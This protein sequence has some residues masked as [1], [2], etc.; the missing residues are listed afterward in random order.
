MLR[1]LTSCASLDSCD[2][3]VGGLKRVTVWSR[4]EGTRVEFGC[5]SSPVVATLDSI[6]TVFLCE[7]GVL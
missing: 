6:S 1:S 5:S 3:S 7:E 4:V 2:D